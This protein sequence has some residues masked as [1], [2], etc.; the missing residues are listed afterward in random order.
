MFVNHLVGGSVETESIAGNLCRA[1][2]GLRVVGCVQRIGP[3]TRR[4]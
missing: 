1:G 3:N 4:D 2:L